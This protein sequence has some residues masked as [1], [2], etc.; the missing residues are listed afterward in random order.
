MGAGSQ[1]GAI[2]T[3]L[4]SMNSSSA[5]PRL[6]RAAHLA[7]VTTALL[8]GA[9]GCAPKSSDLLLEAQTSYDAGRYDDA[10][11]TA[12]AAG[13][14]DDDV[15]RG[16]AAYLA[17]MSAY[18]LNRVAEAEESLNAATRCSD[19]LVAG[20]AHAQ[21]GAIKLKARRLTEAANHFDSAAR[22]LEGEESD[23]ARRQAQNART[24]LA[25]ATTPSSAGST[26]P[27]PS[28]ASNQ[29][30]PAVRPAAP[31]PPGTRWTLQGGCFRDR[32]NAER[33]AKELSRFNS[34]RGLPA[35][36]VVSTSDD[37]GGTV[38]C[39]VMG[40]YADRVAA[41]RAKEKIGRSDFFSRPV[42]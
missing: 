37:S 28:V 38:Y 21:L 5:H 26:A 10:L 33:T 31:P 22:L 27:S 23:R 13:T 39:V 40:D 29:A 41:E 17:G 14:S 2:V 12:E 30:A 1:G 25:Y 42:P 24:E 34:S 15:L 19:S 36:R 9:V 35:A 4:G 7:T 11:T 6:R 18:R 3:I 8:L 16:S 20:R 32:V